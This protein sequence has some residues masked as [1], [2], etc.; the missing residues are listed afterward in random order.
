M[1]ISTKGRYGLRAMV[2]LAV[3]SRDEC[4]SLKSIAQRQGISENYLEQLIA[5]LKKA[6]LVKSVR[7]AQGGYMLGKE[8][9]EISVGDIIKALEGP[10]NLVDC[11]SGADNDSS[12]CGSASCK[13]CVTKN[14]WERISLSINE[15][16]DGITLEDLM[17]DQENINMTGAEI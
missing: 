10:L 1:K 7:G 11:V 9:N 6:D 12:V 14:V 5:S 13:G 17:K 3:N 4:I 2:D 8:P 16:V 15:V